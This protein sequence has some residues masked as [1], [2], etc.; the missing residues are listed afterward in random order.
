M[1]NTP[2]ALGVVVASSRS[3]LS[4]STWSL[5][6]SQSDSERN[7]CSF[8]ARESWAP[9]M[10]S[11]LTSPVRVLCRSLVT[12]TLPDTVGNPHVDS[13]CSARDQSAGNTLLTGLVLVPPRCVWSWLSLLP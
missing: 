3:S 7:H 6:S 2:H 1:T 11:V 8:W 4:R 12:A 9:T 10:G 5:R 13:F